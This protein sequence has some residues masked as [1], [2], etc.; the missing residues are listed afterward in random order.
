LLERES[1][2]EVFMSAPGVG[3]IVTAMFIGVVDDAKRFTRAHQLESY[4]GLV[5][6]EDTKILRA[7]P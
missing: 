4:L 6:S 1:I 5:P 7:R 3:V 2:A